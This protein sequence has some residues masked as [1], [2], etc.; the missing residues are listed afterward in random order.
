MPS[1]INTILHDSMDGDDH[2]NNEEYGFD[3][4]STFDK[5]KHAKYMEKKS[6]KDNKLLAKWEALDGNYSRSDSLKKLIRKGIPRQY[7]CEVWMSVSSARK[8]QFE[9]E[10]LYDELSEKSSDKSEC[11]Q[12]KDTSGECQI[13]IIKRDLKRTFPENPSF[14]EP[15]MLNNMQDVLMAFCFYRPQIGYCQGLN[16]IVGTLLLATQ[17][18][19][20]ELRPEESFWLLVALIDILPDYYS[21]KMTNLNSD[22]LVLN[23]LVRKTVPQTYEIVSSFGLPIQMFITK[24]FV[25]LFVDI[26]P[27]QTVLHIWDTL[28]YE[29]EKILFRVAVYQFVLHKHSL[30][31]IQDPSGLAMFFRN[32]FWDNKAWDDYHY[33]KNVFK[34]SSKV[35]RQ[36]IGKQRERQT[37]EAE[38]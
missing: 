18:E 1:T 33:M 30:K 14:K 19:D 31:N 5:V 6:S 34:K 20:G 4:P 36:N 21:D 25:C 38:V 27:F 26:L 23:E 10:G 8:L 12:V 28:F 22:C 3:W 15:V 11:S 7:R 17:R 24:W 35:S 16:F 9:N 13:D 32:L 29:G 37:G 2:S